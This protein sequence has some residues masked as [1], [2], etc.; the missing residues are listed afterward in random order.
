MEEAKDNVCE[1]LEKEGVECDIR[2]YK[3]SPKAFENNSDFENAIEA[4]NSLCDFEMK[5]AKGN[6]K[7]ILGYKKS[8]ALI[9]FYRNTPNNTISSYWNP[10]NGWK[11]LFIRGLDKPDF[12]NDRGHKKKSSKFNIPY[13]LEKKLKKKKGES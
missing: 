7:F 4:R 10:Y 11:P 8:E 6:K 3:L 5:L 1:F 13:N 9:S 12:M 2:P